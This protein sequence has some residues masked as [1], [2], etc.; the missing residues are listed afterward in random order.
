MLLEMKVSGLTIDPITNTPIVILKDLQESK[1]IPIWIGLFEASAIATELEH[2]V[3]SRPMTH[4]LMH[5]FLKALDVAVSRIEIVDIRN[6]TFFATVYLVRDGQTY[7]IDAR[8]S[9]AIAL[10]LRAN[11]SIFVE[12]SVLEKSRNIDFGI[13]LADIDKF[14]ED[15]VK[16]FLENLSAEDF[17]KYKM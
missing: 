15:K 5:E 8:P 12:E 14:K 3:F 6:N 1:A 11:A 7:R 10:A 13:K 2:V 9:D 16:E 17:G 4:D